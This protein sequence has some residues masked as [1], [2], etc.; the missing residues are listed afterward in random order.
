MVSWAFSSGA[1]S[2]LPL[3]VYLGFCPASGLHK[4][5]SRTDYSKH[6]SSFSLIFMLRLIFVS[7]F[8]VLLKLVFATQNCFSAVIFEHKPQIFKTLYLRYASSLDSYLDTHVLTSKYAKNFIS[9]EAEGRN[10]KMC[11]LLVARGDSNHMYSRIVLTLLHAVVVSW[12]N[13]H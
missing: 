6:S 3:I 2:P 9:F 8:L 1:T 4:P 7:S 5:Y 13:L 10:F 11:F 12:V